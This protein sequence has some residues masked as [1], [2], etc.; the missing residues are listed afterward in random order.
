MVGC[1]WLE[2]V[3]LTKCNVICCHIINI[4]T[5]ARK[6]IAKTTKIN[7]SECVTSL[8]IWPLKQTYDN[9]NTYIYAFSATV[10]TTS[11]LIKNI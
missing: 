3:Y 4:L 7:N 5:S 2:I 8:T 6:T 1:L 11:C 9:D 10:V